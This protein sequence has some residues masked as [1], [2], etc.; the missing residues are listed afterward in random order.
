MRAQ[1]GQAIVLI[2]IMLAVI[3]G[4]AALAIDGSRAYALRRDIQAAVDA[5]ALAAGDR[6]QQTGVYVS[7]EQAATASFGANLR[8]YSG[9]S[10]LPGYG[11]PSV[12]SWTVRCTFSDGTVL[13]DV[14]TNA[15]PGGG[16]FQLTATRTLQL[17]FARILTSGQDASI[18]VTAGVEAGGLRYAPVVAAL[19]QAGCGTPGNALTVAGSGTL[20]VTGDVVSNGRVAVST[21]AA[22]VAG[23]LYARCQSS[24]AGVTNACYSSGGGTPCSYP[25]VAGATRSGFRLSDPGY[26][27]PTSLATG[28]GLPGTSVN[29]VAGVYSGSPVLDGGHCWFLGGGVYDLQGGAV[30]SGDF[31]SNELK[32]P[33]EPQVG[34]NTA[35][36]PNQFWNTDGVDCAGS[37]DV[38]KFTGARDIAL[39]TWAFVVTSVRAD[40]YNGVSY[41]RESAPSMCRQVT[42]T[43]HFDNVQL[44]VSNLPG[45]TSYNIYAAPPPNG[46]AG[47]FGLAANLPV[48]APVSNT[49]T[50]SCPLFTGASC[51]LGHEFANLDSQLV[52]PFAPNAT[53]A[54]GTTG[55]YP[56]DSETSPLTAGLP[57]QNP[58]RAAG[59][60]G[61]RANENNCEGIAPGYTTC[62][63]AITPG[64]VEL[65]L[66][67]AACL[68]VGNGADTY[69]FS[70][71]QYDW[72]ALYQP[73]A[74]R[75]T[76]GMGAA[77]NSAYVGLVYAPGAQIAV[78][79]PYA[80]EAGGTAGVMGDTVSFTG[81]LPSIAYR[82]AYAPVPPASR[83]TS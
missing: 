34:N 54:P 41:P 64:A 62:P 48:T 39:G 36:S 50:N 47:P 20:G 52:A 40:T 33:D 82:A 70:G 65:Y 5:A 23:D 81:T 24:V 8:L 12:G 60:R 21:G 80:F 68:T 27:A 6:L 4:M 13:I 38:T 73:A 3:V 37:F 10:C 67:G 25:D 75:C 11:T 63:A 2:A 56:P 58:A 14:A 31:V 74:D 15:G 43:S 9:A 19:D 30:N 57:N 1:K 78:S 16:S 69:L 35:R 51:S 22:R 83:I 71:Y 66:P 44:T 53:A 28:Q 17:Q 59:S 26:P 7:A 77:G 55:A 32:P 72:I 18:S 29:L 46:C 49:S 42:L 79:S 45:A 76:V 61:D